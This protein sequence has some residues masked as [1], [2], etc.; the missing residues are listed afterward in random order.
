MSD[1]D[2]NDDDT[3]NRIAEEDLPVD[4]RTGGEHVGSRNLQP[5]RKGQSG[6]P[7][8]K[9]PGTLSL[10]NQLKRDLR[11]MKWMEEDPELADIINGLDN[12]EMFEALKKTSFALFVQDPKDMTKYDRAYKAIAED[13]EYTEGKKVRTEID[14]KDKQIS[15]MTVEELEKQLEDIESTD[16]EEINEGDDNPK[17]D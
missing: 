10:K 15:E 9:I 12:V 6:N 8:G 2:N 1:K 17:E 11:I 4:K 5:W 7:K 3:I 14:L 13:R 16:Y